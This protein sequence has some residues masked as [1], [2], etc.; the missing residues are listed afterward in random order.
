[1][2]TPGVPLVCACGHN[3]TVHW[4]NDGGCQKC[5]CR[6]YQRP[7]SLDERLAAHPPRQITE[8]ARLLELTPELRAHYACD[9]ALECGHPD[10][11]P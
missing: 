3:I 8:G 4:V 9:P 1:M 10:C 7:E 11:Q 5:P 2:T 6:V